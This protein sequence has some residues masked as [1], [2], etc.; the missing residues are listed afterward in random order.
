MKPEL[1][2]V[3][4]SSDQVLDES[5][6][7]T[8]NGQDITGFT[9]VAFDS[10]GVLRSAINAV[11]EETG[12]VASQDAAG[13]LKLVAEDGR[14]IEV[15]AT[16]DAANLG[17][18]GGVVQGASLRLISKETFKVDFASHA[19]NTSA[20]GNIGTTALGSSTPLAG[21]SSGPTLGY[22]DFDR[23]FDS[24]G[25]AGTEV[26]LNEVSGVFIENGAQNYSGHSFFLVFEK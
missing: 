25:V 21:V 24:S 20:L 11:F 15:A 13:N 12:V 5:G 9:A 26:S 2:E 1:F 10:D 3:G 6:V 8:I 4:F 22:L 18:G 19:V 17:F 7:L 16:G 14:N 23:N